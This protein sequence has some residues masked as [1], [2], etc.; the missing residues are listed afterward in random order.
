MANEC[1]TLESRGV[2]AVVRLDDLS[3]AVEVAEALIAGGVTAVE[4]TFT[5]P[6]AAR[7]IEAA[8]RAVGERG[9][10]GA[11]T[12]LDPETARTAILAGAE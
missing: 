2:I 4:F 11:G 5:N 12:V 3:T 1:G 7:A 10:I 8:K 9:Y 6:A